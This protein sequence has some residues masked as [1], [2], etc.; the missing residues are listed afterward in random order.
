MANPL[1]ELR[2]GALLAYSPKGTSAIAERSRRGLRDPLK[3]G[4]V[5]TLALAFRRFEELKGHAFFA[6]VLGSD[7]TLV[8]APRSAAVKEG[9]LWPARS[10]AEALVDAGAGA[11]VRSYLRRIV[12][13]PKS[14]FSAPGERPDLRTHMNSMK[15]E[16]G[17]EGH[18]RLTV[19]DDFVTRGSTL[20]ACARLLAGAFP[21]AEIGAFAL[22][23]T[24]GLVAD[25]ERIID[26]VLGSIMERNGEAFRSHD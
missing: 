24:R 14:A 23:R 17:I 10:I 1:S 3:L 13:V 21:D 2:F 22:V 15:V 5:P 9:S 26:P 4:H 25:I 16:R 12:K 20:L 7:V 11:E 18:L 6:A 19:V 8:P